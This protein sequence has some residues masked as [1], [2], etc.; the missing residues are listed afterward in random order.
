MAFQCE[1]LSKT[2]HTRDGEILALDKISFQVTEDAFVCLVGPSGCGKTT[3]LKIIA[4]LL[5]ASAGQL[6]FPS[7][8]SS[9]HPPC[10]LVFQEHGVF[11]WMNVLDN[12]A[13]GLKMQGIPRQARYDQAN[14]FIKKMG[15]AN[16]GH[17]YPHELSVGMRQRVG[18]ARAF[19]VKPRILLMDEPFGALDVQTKL[20]MQEELRPLDKVWGL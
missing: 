5:P 4:G 9:P 6:H 3:L 18:I 7:S 2:Y 14:T 1:N 12:V 10:A 13:F 19:L 20:I 17:H 16:F 15:L 8:Q 11:P